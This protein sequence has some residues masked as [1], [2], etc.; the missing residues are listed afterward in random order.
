MI[1]EWAFSGLAE[2]RRLLKSTFSERKSMST[3]TSIK[4]IAAVAAAALTIGGFSAVSAHAATTLTSVTV[5]T[6][7][8]VRTGVTAVIPV[9]VNYSAAAATDTIT[10][11]A[12]TISAPTSGGNAAVNGGASVFSN[13]AADSSTNSSTDKRLYL[14]TDS[15]GGLAGTAVYS[16]TAAGTRTADTSYLGVTGGA[17]GTI[18]AAAP[19][20]K[21]ETAIQH[22]VADST[23]AA[24]LVLKEYLVVK[25]DVAG[26]YTFLISASTTAGN[27]AYVAGDTSTLLTV[28]SAGAPATATVTAVGGSSSTSPSATYGALFKVA[29]KDANGNPT[30][31]GGQEAFTIT[32]SLG[33]VAKSTNSSGTWSA[34]SASYTNTTTTIAAGDMFNGAA[35]FNARYATASSTVSVVGAGDGSLSSSVTASATYT[36]GKAD[37]ALATNTM[38]GGLAVTTGYTYTSPNVTVPS[39]NT[40]DTLELDWAAALTAAKYGFLNVVDTSGKISGAATLKFDIYYSGAIGDTYETITIPHSAIATSTYHVI[41]S[42]R[43]GLTDITVTGSAAVVSA[44]TISVTPSVVRLAT[45]GSVTYTATVKDQYSNVL[46]ND[47]VAITV[48][49]RNSAQSSVTL[50]TNASGVI[51]YTFSDAGTTGTT[52]SITFNGGGTATKTVTV[53]Y[54]TSTPATVTVTGGATADVAPAKT[55]TSISTGNIGYST[56]T[57]VAF[58]ATVLDASGNP[59]SGVP[60]TFSVDKGLI[61]KS[62]TTDYSTVYTAADGTATTYAFDWITEKQTITAKAGTVSGTGY[63]N[64]RDD[65]ASQARSV[66]VATDATLGNVINMTVTDRFGNGVKGANVTLSRAGTGFFFGGAST[67]SATTGSDGTVSVQFNGS[68]TVTA[69]LDA[70][71]EGYDIA[72]QVQATALKAAVAGTTTGTGA[73]LSA[74]GVGAASATVNA[75]SDASTVAAQAAVDAA[76]EATDAANA[77]T[78]AAN[79]AMDSADAAQQAALDAGDKAD[80]ALAAVTDLATKVSAIASQIAALSALVKKIAAKVKA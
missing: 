30:T 3:K 22:A 36:T 16:T 6:V 2:M 28:T 41:D 60:V 70:T 12:Q 80:A 71:T 33:Y 66:A 48:A 40:S 37:S 64:W 76:N 51:S 20:A 8:A 11:A 27:M 75:G 52:D 46:P 50:V 31:L 9:N 78:D 74:A 77:A 29:F 35:Y 49:G 44:G 62:A 15:K 24:T 5:G 72:G 67:T 79:N 69:T 58:T 26:T 73:T 14:T 10:V 4:R 54:G 57:S 18:T 38:F 59:L 32:P 61:N 42:N 47:S 21:P 19:N 43:S 63:A 17:A 45:G 55:W 34:P 53:L 65:V 56:S 1:N 7:P 68:G 25:L 23:E 13:T 39:T